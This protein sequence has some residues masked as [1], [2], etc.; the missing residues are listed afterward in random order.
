MQKN[1]RQTSVGKANV[2]VAGRKPTKRSDLH[3]GPRSFPNNLSGQAV[4]VK[5]FDLFLTTKKKLGYSFHLISTS[6]NLSMNAEYFYSIVVFMVG[7]R[8][9][10]N[11]IVLLGMIENSNVD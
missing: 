7:V 8:F 10:D 4:P 6:K 3:F 1:K 5:R 11:P 2:H 9:Y